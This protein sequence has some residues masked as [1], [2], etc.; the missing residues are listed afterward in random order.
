MISKLKKLS[1]LLLPAI[2]QSQMVSAEVQGND[3]IQVFE[4]L[5][6]K[7][8]GVRKGHAKGVCALGDFIPSQEAMP[9]SSSRLFSGQ[10]IKANIR[11]SMAGGN[12]FADETARS[13]RGVGIQFSLPDGSIHNIAGLTTPVFPGK[14]PQT[15]LGL[16]KTLVPNEQGKVDFA[17]VSQYRQDHPSTQ[18][19]FNWLRTHNPPSSYSR[20]QY[21]GI[22]AFYF[23]DEAGHKTKFKWRLVPVAGELPLTSKQM[24]QLPPTFLADNLKQEL[25]TDSVQ[26]ELQAIIGHDDDVTDDPS[27]FWPKDRLIISLGL[28]TI[29]Q[30]GDSSCDEINYD[31]NVLS[32]GVEPS[33]DPVLKLRSTAYAISFGKR[34]SGN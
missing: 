19:Q 27:L 17:K 28:L 32:K 13:P 18:A 2:M 31:P 11:F 25:I 34:L 24:E 12:P 9:Y 30:S 22:H 6:G 23:V 3:F 15:F 4:Q 8:L 26:F 21:F 5:S 16:L 10:K 20:A 1:I 14:D 29:N 33:D 7:H